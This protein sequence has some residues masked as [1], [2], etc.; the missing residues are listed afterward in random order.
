[1]LY[2]RKTNM[3]LSVFVVVFLL[4]PLA[5]SVRAY[6]V[7]NESV[8]LE[9]LGSARRQLTRLSNKLHTLNR[10]V[11]RMAWDIQLRE[12]A[13][14]Q[15]DKNTQWRT[16]MESTRLKLIDGMDNKFHDENQIRSATLNWLDVDSSEA[17]DLVQINKVELKA[18]L[19][20]VPEAHKFMDNIE[21]L[22]KPYPLQA[23]GC[24]YQRVENTSEINMECLLTIS[25]WDL[26][27]IKPVK[28]TDTSTMRSKQINEQG[29]SLEKTKD[30]YWRLF[31]PL[32]SLG[33][34]NA[35]M[36]NEH[37]SQSYNASYVEM[38]M[39][40]KKNKVAK[41]VFT[42]P[43]GILVIHAPAK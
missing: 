4:A 15:A 38:P 28:I 31:S 9:E 8:V 26:P 2:R 1:M 22:V 19:Q 6:L 32:K 25:V 35:V 10:Y 33:T 11:D 17:D 37:S 13:S 39:I 41:G 24:S 16:P 20:S 5:N 23:H 27:V 14:T 29:A 21:T 36:A 7:A 30:S 40:K 12:V 43:E 42:G 18:K 3:V 34:A